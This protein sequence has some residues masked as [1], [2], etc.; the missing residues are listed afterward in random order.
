MT[1][2]MG[3]TPEKQQS[4]ET[5]MPGGFRC[6]ALCDVTST[7]DEA[8]RRGDAGAAG[9]LVITAVSQNLGRGRQNRVWNSPPG[10]L[11]SSFL[12][13]PDCTLAAAPQLGFVAVL[14]VSDVVRAVLPADR[15]VVV[16]WP[17][18]VLVDGLKISGIL[19]ESKSKAQ[20]GLS[21]LVMGIGINAVSHPP[22]SPAFAT[23]LRAAGLDPVPDL[24][25]LCAKLCLQIRF[26]MDRWSHEGFAALRQAWRERAHGMGREARVSGPDGPLTGKLVDLDVDGALILEH[27]TRG[28]I[29]I[30]AGDVVLG[31]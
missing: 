12:L 29:R 23:D 6:L 17:N 8:K 28:R 5:E 26:W 9:D 27:A 14:A 19:L 3:E 10:N 21:W 31:G 1:R 22:G 7:N 30:S 20:G 2:P 15:A 13:R 18:D 11:Y 25:V 16:K 24:S 4:P